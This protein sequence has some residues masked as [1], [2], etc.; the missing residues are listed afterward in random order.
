[1]KKSKLKGQLQVPFLFEPT[2]RG[3]RIGPHPPPPWVELAIGH[4]T[5]EGG[6]TRLW[7]LKQPLLEFS[8]SRE[9]KWPSLMGRNYRYKIC[10]SKI[11]VPSIRFLLPS[12][13][14]PLIADPGPAMAKDR[15][16]GHL[17]RDEMNFKSW[18]PPP[19]SVFF[20]S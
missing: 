11:M 12:S 16:M 7:R 3:P 19:S 17:R 8:Q 10:R 14:P 2:P 1:M 5:L 4:L 18:P 6:S 9:K 20:P 13:P 15:M